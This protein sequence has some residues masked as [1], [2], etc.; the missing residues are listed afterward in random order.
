MQDLK[1][2]EISGFSIVLLPVSASAARKIQTT[3]L[4]IVAEPLAQAL[5]EKG[6]LGDFSTMDKAARKS[7]QLMA[8]MKGLAAILPKLNDG[9][10]DEI[11]NNCKPFIKVN[12]KPFN[13]DEQFEAKTLMAMYE[14][15]WY[16]L[17]ETFEDFINAIRLRFNQATTMAA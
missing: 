13:E 2:T 10:L 7:M 11:I 1:S 12:G 14:I 4:A 17:R 5:G 16:F 15:I 6:S 9:Q 8:G 3:L